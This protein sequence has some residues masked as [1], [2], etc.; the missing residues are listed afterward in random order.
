M[1]VVA[2]D[3]STD[4]GIDTVAELCSSQPLTLLVNNAGV[5]HNMP[6]ADLSAA[7]ARELLQRRMSSPPPWP[8]SNS[9]KS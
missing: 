7:K 6:M 9:A 2:A 3:L 1:Q 8:A 4:D 5:A